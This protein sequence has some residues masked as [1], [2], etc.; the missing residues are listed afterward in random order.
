MT[1]IS[2]FGATND[3]EFARFLVEEIGVAAVPGSSFYHDPKLGQKHIRF[4]F[5]KKLSTIERGVQAL[6]GLPRS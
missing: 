6:K 1:D 3:V 4:S 5:P 2:A